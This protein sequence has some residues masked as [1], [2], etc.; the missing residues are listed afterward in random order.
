M[1][2]LTISLGILVAGLALG[3]LLARR[4][5]ARKASHQNIHGRIDQVSGQLQDA[6]VTLE[7]QNDELDAAHKRALQA[8]KVKSEFLA[9]MSHEIRTPMNGIIGFADLLSH[10][11]LTP[12]QNDYV[13]T[14]RT[15]AANLLTIVNDILDFSKIESGKLILENSSFDLR[16]T[17]D[18]ALALLAPA[19]HDKGLE[20]VLL[21]YHDVP[22]RLLGDP[23][24]IRQI[25][26]NL[27]SNAVK[28][29]HQG[30]VV[31]RVMIEEND[32]DNALIRI[33]IN[34]TGIGLT[35]Q[36]QLRL[37][38]AF[39]QGD[40]SATRR[41]GGTGLGLII[42]K[43]L[44]EDMGGTIGLESER[45][46]GSTFWFKVRWDKQRSAQNTSGSRVLKDCSALV[47]DSHP[48]AK[49]AASHTLQS[50][51]AKVTE[52][53]TLDAVAAALDGSD[54]KA[55]AYNLVLI[56][57]DKKE[58]GR[59]IAAPLLKSL[60]SRSV[61]VLVLIGSDNPDHMDQVC[62][63]GAKACLS[64]PARSEVLYREIIELISDLD[65]HRIADTDSS[66]RDEVKPQPHTLNVLL[67]DDNDINRKLITIQLQQ[68]GARVT[69]V[70]NGRKA[71]QL[72]EKQ[73]FDI[74][75]MDIQM[76]EMDGEEAAQAIR[77]NDTLNRNTPIIAITANALPG[78]TD[79]L[80]T[81]GLDDCLIKPIAPAVLDSIL[82][83]WGGALVK[84][85]G[86]TAQPATPM[87][88]A[89]TSNDHEALEPVGGNQQLAQEMRALLLLEL[90]EHQEQLRKSY[91]NH[92]LEALARH[93]HK[94]HGSAA[95]CGVPNLKEC[96]A[97][98][99]KE[100]LQR[101]SEL[102]PR[103]LNKTLNAIQELLREG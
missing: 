50:W 34:D 27:V 74:I 46:A 73:S 42:S 9:N 12:K 58:G 15:S 67:A 87:D 71:L 22:L 92:D 96:V 3:L 1:N 72:A 63:W 80:L 25:V 30:S 76:P 17:M 79:R 98:L 64:K 70:S 94:L 51:G 88:A 41:F 61:P 6:L 78:E 26:I 35:K 40:T 47:Y 2:N 85:N 69:E 77:Y 95:Y 5:S 4:H 102:I 23:V 44:V 43:R 99:E 20:L 81:S 90:P 37:F 8:S 62:A 19:A 24:R 103:T 7:Q 65:R 48:L 14:I 21:V 86:G 45:G 55:M 11:K 97:R 52:M 66:I 60:S 82:T 83:R 57:F 91:A 28:F 38:E 33:S 18:D 32:K 53:P 36:E 16:E 75:L 59:A 100:A 101:H 93:A 31:V 68:L 29:T 13:E 49:L 54:E 56:G 84:G 89:Q 10:T 39:S